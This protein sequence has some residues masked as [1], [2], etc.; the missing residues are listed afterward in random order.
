MD[1]QSV[2]QPMEDVD[3]QEMVITDD[4]DYDIDDTM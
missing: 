3:E 4:A 2:G 1:V